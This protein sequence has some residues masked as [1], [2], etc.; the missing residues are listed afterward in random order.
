MT[1]LGEILEQLQG[2]QI[3]KVLKVLEIIRSPYYGAF[4]GLIQQ[5][6]IAHAEA[7]DNLKYLMSLK[8]HFEGVRAA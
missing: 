6:Q 2:P 8:P 4:R 7:K 1:D 5:L 3:A